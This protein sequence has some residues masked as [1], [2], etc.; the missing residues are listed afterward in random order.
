MGESGWIALIPQKR[1]SLRSFKHEFRLTRGQHSDVPEQNMPPTT[2]FEKS[3]GKLNVHESPRQD[4]DQGFGVSCGDHHR[5]SCLP[6]AHPS[7][8]LKVFRCGPQHDVG[9][10]E[11]AAHV[12]KPRKEEAAGVLDHPMGKVPRRLRQ[13]LHQGR[14]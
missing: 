4:A 9:G 10:H 1:P 12:D 7:A 8:F 11:M 14:G 5:H 13:R 3:H 2:D 6:H